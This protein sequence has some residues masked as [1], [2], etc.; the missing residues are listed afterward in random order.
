MQSKSPRYAHYPGTPA[1]TKG[2]T[3]GKQGI[4]DLN[5]LKLGSTYFRERG[6]L[7]L[8]PKAIGV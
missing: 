6:T 2:E 7:T 1:G 3:H 8:I 5:L 4:R